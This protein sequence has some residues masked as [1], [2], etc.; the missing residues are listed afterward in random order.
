M[1]NIFKMVNQKII[2]TPGAVMESTLLLHEMMDQVMTI[3]VGGATTD[4]HTVCDAKPEFQK[5]SEGEP[6]FKRTVEG[7]LGVYV[8]R[9][10]VHHSFKKG[11][12]EHALN[13]SQEEIQQMILDEPFIPITENGKKMIDLMT[14]Q[15]VHLALDRHIGDLRRVFTT[16]GMKV[17]PDGK[18]ASLVKSIFLTGGALLYATNPEKMVQDYLMKQSTKLIPDQHAKIYLDH[19]YIFASIGVLSLKYPDQAKILLKKTIRDEGE[20]HVS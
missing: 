11:E 9:S 12:L 20:A 15:C 2:P 1:Q 18:D 19:E 5:Y 10:L 14:R 13:L 7:D 4:V 3:D 8:N 6:K 17:I 16:N